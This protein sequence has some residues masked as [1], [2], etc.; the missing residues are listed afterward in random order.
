MTFLDEVEPLVLKAAIATVRKWPSYVSLEDVEQE[1]RLWAL[2][3][4]NS[5]EAAMKIDG[6]EAKVYSTMLKVASSAASLEDQQTNGYSKEDTYAYSVPVLETLLESCFT[7][8]DWQSFGTFGDGQPHAKGQVNETG[9]VLAML[10]DVKAGIAQLKAEYREVLFYRYGLHLTFPDIGE[11][12]GTTRGT[13]E[14]RAKR[15]VKALQAALGQVDLSDLQ[16]GYSE[17]RE[18]LDSDRSQII[19]E[20]QYN[21]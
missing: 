15:A 5:V 6:W 11:R 2:T 21:G 18:V 14:R 9:D 13:V 17:R 20:R 16:N 3:K 12:L 10:S 4:Q 19:T 1:L 7:Y 8:E